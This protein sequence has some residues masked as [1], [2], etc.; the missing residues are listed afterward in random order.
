MRYFDKRSQKIFSD[1]DK[2][3]IGLDLEQMQRINLVIGVA[4]GMAKLRAIPPAL[5]GQLVD[6][7]V[8][9]HVTAQQLLAAR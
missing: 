4:G 2:R 3:V 6:V 7:L 5:K 1:L 9:D 8:T